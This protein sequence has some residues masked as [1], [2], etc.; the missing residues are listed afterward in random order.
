MAARRH[1]REKKD[2]N[3]RNV[4]QPKKQKKSCC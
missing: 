1:K 3:A 4:T 2:S